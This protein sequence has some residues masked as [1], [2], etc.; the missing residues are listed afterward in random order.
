[1][2]FNSTDNHVFINEQIH[3]NAQATTVLLASL[4][5]DEYNK[6]SGLDNAKQIWDTLKISHEGND[7]TMITKMELV[8]G[9]LG[10]FAMIRGEEP[11]QTYNRL[12]TLVNKIRSYGSTRWTDHDIVRLML[13]SFTV[14]DPHLVNLIRENPRYTKMTPE[15]ILG[16]FVS[17]HMMV[18]EA[19]CVDDA[20]NGPLPVHEPQTVALKA[21][22]SREAL[23]SNVAQVEAA[24]LNE[25][26]MALIIKRFK[27]ALKRTQGAPQQEQSKGEALLLQMR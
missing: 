26:E 5:R 20:L 4:C 14:I 6:V 25:E 8:E 9:E 7:A 17:G 23:P 21:T 27:T 10:R 18:K 11:T 22:S 19:R 2:H 24:G 13:R 3:K 12:K 16:K 1:M 15:K